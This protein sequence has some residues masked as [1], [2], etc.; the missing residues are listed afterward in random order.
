MQSKG[1]CSIWLTRSLGSDSDVIKMKLPAEKA[2]PTLQ[3]K[4]QNQKGSILKNMPVRRTSVV[5]LY[6]LLV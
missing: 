4:L 2:L 6:S 3:K 1:E 5:L